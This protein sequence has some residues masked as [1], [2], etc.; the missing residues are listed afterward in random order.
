MQ[1]VNAIQR[2]KLRFRYQ[3][4]TWP[5]HAHVSDLIRRVILLFR[6]HVLHYVLIM[7]QQ[8]Q[9]PYCVLAVAEDLHPRLAVFVKLQPV[10]HL[11]P[12]RYPVVVSFLEVN[13]ILEAVLRYCWTV[14]ALEDCRIRHAGNV[15]SGQ[16]GM[17]PL[18]PCYLAEKVI[19]CPAHAC[20]RYCF[21]GAMLHAVQ[22]HDPVKDVILTQAPPS[23]RKRTE[24][25]PVQ[26]SEY[27]PVGPRLKG[28]DNMR[29]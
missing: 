15:L 23:N 12:P 9:R 26:T 16:P 27:R 14:I 4:L 13:A 19:T 8:R 1:R 21:P 18:D 6:V 24:F 28:I 20:V 22:L 7:F 2:I 5:C 25:T 29:P 3:R 17:L 11:V 10:P